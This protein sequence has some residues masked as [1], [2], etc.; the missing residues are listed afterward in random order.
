MLTRQQ[1]D[2]L[3]LAVSGDLDALTI[4]TDRH[5]RKIAYPAAPAAKPPTPEQGQWRS[6][7]AVGMFLWSQL[8]REERAKY[9][10]ACDRLSLCMLG[11][12]LWLHIFLR[13]DYHLL[14]TIEAQTGLALQP[15]PP[16]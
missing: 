8:P 2:A 16:L 4:Y 15:P 14:D 9:R 11:H 10:L 13:Q 5:G 6:N 1:I 7:L 3:G 12:N